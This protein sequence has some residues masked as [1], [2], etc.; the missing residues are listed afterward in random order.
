DGR[1][2]QRVP[3]RLKDVRIAGGRAVVVEP[4]AVRLADD[5]V[6]GEREDRARDHRARRE[7]EEPEQPGQE[8]RERPPGVALAKAGGPAPGPATRARRL[9][10]RCRRSRHEGS[11]SA[12]FFA[13]LIALTASFWAWSSACFGVC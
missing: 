11:A 1:H 12:Y 10:F 9:D 3:Q 7:D 5:A 4:D 8:E 13:A 2:D 6:V